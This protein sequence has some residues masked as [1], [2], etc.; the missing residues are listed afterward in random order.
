MSKQLLNKVMKAASVALL[1][2]GMIGGASFANN[3]SANGIPGVPTSHANKYGAAA[4]ANTY[5]KNYKHASMSKL[6]KLDHAAYEK[7]TAKHSKKSSKKP[8]KKSSKKS[9]KVT[10]E[11]RAL[12]H[13]K[14]ISRRAEKPLNHK[15]YRHAANRHAIKRNSKFVKSAYYRNVWTRAEKINK[16]GIRKD[17]KAM[18]YDQ[19]KGYK[20]AVKYLQGKIN[21]LNGYVRHDEN[22]LSK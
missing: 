6:I 11:K 5:N 13:A 18:K 17:K 21:Y 12:N 10:A 1:A 22:M 19:K 16:A 15:R 2:G 3:A 4:A 14:K 20:S 9:A 7:A 8:A